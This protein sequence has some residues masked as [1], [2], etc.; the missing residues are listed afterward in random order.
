MLLSLN[1]DELALT[2]ALDSGETDLVF[3]VMTRLRDK[4]VSGDL[5]EPVIF[6]KKMLLTL[7]LG[8]FAHTLNRLRANS[9]A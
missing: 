6:L 7:I 2:K 1:E 9:T 4:M 8:P 5:A 3:L